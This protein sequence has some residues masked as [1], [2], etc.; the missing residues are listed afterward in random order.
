VA[1]PFEQEH[2]LT[3]S[4]QLRDQ[5][6]YESRQ[7][8]LDKLRDVVRETKACPACTASAALYL[9]TIAGVDLG[10]DKADFLKL[11]EEVW[12]DFFRQQCKVGN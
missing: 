3:E 1:N 8:V 2:A 11:A 10:F 12:D 5:H 7:S 6:G 4:N 9:A